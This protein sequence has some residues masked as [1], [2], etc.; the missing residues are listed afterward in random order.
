MARRTTPTPCSQLETTGGPRSG[1]PSETSLGGNR[2]G[3]PSS[4]GE[5]P[6]RHQV[7]KRPPKQTDPPGEGK[8]QQGQDPL[9]RWLE[10]Y[11]QSP[12]QKRRQLNVEPFPPQSRPA[13]QRMTKTHPEDGPEKRSQEPNGSNSFTRD[14]NVRFRPEKGDPILKECRPNIQRRLRFDRVG[15]KS[16]STR[17]VAP[18]RSN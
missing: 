8:R 18:L 5:S 15:E 17:R 2:Q 1:P 10:G 14:Q 4:T 6:E 7:E 3:E 16:H 11:P 13:E 9:L 12:R